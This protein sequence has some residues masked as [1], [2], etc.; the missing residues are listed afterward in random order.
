MTDRPS[1]NDL[2]RPVLDPAALRGLAGDVVHTIAPHTEADPAALLLTFLTM[3]GAAVGPAPHAMADA[4]EHPARLFPVLVGDTSKARKGSAHAQVR[5]L[6]VRADPDFER[7]RMLGGFGSGES[8]I[9]A[10]ADGEDRR[11]LVF[12]PEF[13]RLLAVAKR[14][15]STISQLLRQAWDGDRL[16]VRSRAKTTV[17]DGAHVALVGHITAEELSARLTDTDAA[18]GFANRHLF[19]LVRRFQLL[20][21]GGNLD[22]AEVARLGDEISH[23][24]RLARTVGIMRRTPETETRW[25]SLYRTMA[26]DQP[27]GLLGSVIAR[28]TA[29]VLRLSVAYALLD[30]AHQIDLPHVEAAWA[31]WRYCRRS[32]EIIFGDRLGDEVADRLLSA[33]RGARANGLTRDE[34]YHALGGHVSAD[35]LRVAR[36]LLVTKALAEE[37]RITTGGRPAEVLRACERSETSERRWSGS[38]LSSHP[39]LLSQSRSERAALLEQRRHKWAKDHPGESVP[40][41]SLFED[42]APYGPPNSRADP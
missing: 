19:A 17:A 8:V 1:S 27:G 24:L 42:G 2:Q 40:R 26:N 18:N 38:T 5:R 21:S 3:F 13:S 22:D 35:R 25:D 28:D 15:G 12:E 37:V 23:A 16:Q 11:L 39:S 7:D 41:L 36:T 33:I 34:Q 29:Q 4:A 14:D 30:G 31:V 9:D 32:A 10:V 20:P 6:M